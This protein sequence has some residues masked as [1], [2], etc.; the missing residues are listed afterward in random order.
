M[1]PCIVANYKLVVD[2]TEEMAEHFR[3]TYDMIV[4]RIIALSGSRVTRSVQ[5]KR[6]VLDCHRKILKDAKDYVYEGIGEGWI[7]E[8]AHVFNTD[9]ARFL[10][11]ALSLVEDEHDEARGWIG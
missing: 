1:D 9:E 11:K 8:R 2:D 4:Y 5:A 7:N 3:R 10:M 6:E